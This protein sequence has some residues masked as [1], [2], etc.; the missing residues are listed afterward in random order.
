LA[1]SRT[2]RT[3][4]SPQQ[5]DPRRDEPPEH[6]RREQDHGR[7]DREPIPPGSREVVRHQLRGGCGMGREWSVV[8]LERSLRAHSAKVAGNRRRLRPRGPGWRSTR[9]SSCSAAFQ[10]QL[11]VGRHQD[12]GAACRDEADRR[13]P[14]AT[15]RR[16]IGDR[17]LPA[18]RRWAS[19]PDGRDPTSRRR[20]EARASRRGRGP[21]TDGGDEVDSPRPPADPGH[22]RRRGGDEDVPTTIREDEEQRDRRQCLESE[23]GLVTPLTGASAA[24]AS[25]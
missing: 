11:Q 10:A 2:V 9:P 8:R 5:R 20:P 24:C 21:C 1:S 14:G 6:Q 17:A 22:R 15:E 4:G 16:N 12:E 3:S 13:D 7:H 25:R 18:W 19:Q 23:Q